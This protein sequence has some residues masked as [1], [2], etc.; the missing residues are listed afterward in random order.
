M[1]RQQNLSI[2]KYNSP[3]SKHSLGAQIIFYL[4]EEECNYTYFYN[5]AVV[6]QDTCNGLIFMWNYIQQE[7]KQ[8]Q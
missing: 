6:W 7:C 5:L 3:Q 2:Y 4:D 8:P 1:T